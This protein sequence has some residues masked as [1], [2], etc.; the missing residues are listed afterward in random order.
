MAELGRLSPLKCV[1]PETIFAEDL[2]Q[3]VEK[4]LRAYLEEAGVLNNFEL[5]ELN[6]IR[7]F[8]VWCCE[9][10]QRVGLSRQQRHL[11][12]NVLFE[13]LRHNNASY[14][15][16][17]HPKTLDSD[18]E[19]LQKLLID[20]PCLNRGQLQRLLSEFSDFY[21]RNFL[22]FNYSMNNPKRPPRKI[23]QVVIDQPIE[24]PPLRE[25]VEMPRSKFHPE[26]G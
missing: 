2:S 6:L 22:V 3:Q 24:V 14:G 17:C 11:I 23:V 20:N 8:V 26:E 16:E 19:L 7:E 21:F 10:C 25:A 13:V 15:G 5:F 4:H 18:Y 9:L 1:L 12:V